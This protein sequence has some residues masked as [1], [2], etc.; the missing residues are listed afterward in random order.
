MRV[1]SNESS[2]HGMCVEV[3]LSFSA[4]AQRLRIGGKDMNINGISGNTSGAPQAGVKRAVDAQSRAIQKQIEDARKRLQE[5]SVNKDLSAEEK[6]KKRQEIQK[7]ISDLNMQLRQHQAEV[8]KQEQEEKRAASEAAKGNQKTA[9]EESGIS[10][11]GMQAV[12]SADASMKQAQV[13]EGTA[14]KME[15]RAN[16]LAAEIKQDGSR[17]TDT[18]AKEA[19]LAK[20]R[21][22]AET[23]EASG[24]NTLKEAELAKARHRAETA[25]ASGMNTLKEANR[26]AEGASEATQD[27]RVKEADTK[28]ET[29]EEK[30][31]EEKAQQTDKEGAGADDNTQKEP[32]MYVDV[33][34]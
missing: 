25:E 2:S 21:H 24:M 19:E 28:T 32:G 18:S 8:R 9:G 5:V 30:A 4:V 10:T 34:L 27:G 12:L 13:Q 15:G 16:V 23:A 3:T 7:E 26:K 11:E 22:R 6:M 17:G 14:K 20:A 1:P 33:R 29:E 31:E